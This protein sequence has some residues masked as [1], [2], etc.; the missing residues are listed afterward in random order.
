[1][2]MNPALFP[3]FLQGDFSFYWILIGFAALVVLVGGI[4]LVKYLNLWLQAFFAK[5]EVSIFQLIGM[6]LRKVNAA[7]IVRSKIM[8]VQANLEVSTQELE[9]HYLAGG[10]VP[11]VARAMIAA[12]RAR[13]ALDFKTARAIDLAGRDVLEAVQQSVLPKV[14]DCPKPEGPKPAIAAVAK[15]GIQL[16]AKAR[17]TVRTNIERLVGGATEETIIARVGEGIV[18]TIGSAE[19]HK[20]VLENPDQISKGVL[21]KGLDAGTAFEILSI[22]IADVDIGENI[23]AKLQAEQAEADKRI[24]QAKAEERRAMAVARETEMSALVAENQAKVV[25]AEAEV[26]KAMA[27]AFRSGNL[28]IMD[29]YRMKNITADTSMREKIVGED[30]GKPG[31]S[32][33]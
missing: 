7:I 32:K 23:G 19:S 10:N 1:M 21:A 29:Y 18:S 5:A 6:T 9:A 20:S 15:D 27:E 31:D 17:V 33:T 8:A 30:E 28:G 2:T 14:I 16:M 22:D 26:P 4:I 25:L 12:D 13:L 3:V 24:A 11:N